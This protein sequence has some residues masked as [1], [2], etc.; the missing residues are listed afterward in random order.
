MSQQSHSPADKSD[1]IDEALTPFIERSI[2]ELNRLLAQLF[3]TPFAVITFN[4]HFQEQLAI[5]ARDDLETAY[6]LTIA[7]PLS[8]FVLMMSAHLLLSGVYVNL[9]FDAGRSTAGAIRLFKKLASDDGL[10]Q[11]IAAALVA[12]A[13]TLIVAVKAHFVSIAGRI[14]GC[15]IHF[16]SALDA[17]AYAFG[18]FI[19]FQYVLVALRD[20]VAINSAAWGYILFVYGSLLVSILLVVRVNQVIRQMDRTPELRTYVAWLIGTIA[21]QFAAVLGATYLSN[22]TL[23]NFWSDYTTYWSA[24]GRAFLLS[25]WH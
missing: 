4:K 23:A 16:K 18:T 14:I 22:K 7:R 21:W 10:G 13:I 25:G 6:P 24:F 1:H 2:V 19:F 17:S 12:F 5:L 9:D 11:T 8:F 15:S 3:T 20:V